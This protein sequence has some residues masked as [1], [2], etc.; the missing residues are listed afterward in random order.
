MVWFF[1]SISGKIRIKKCSSIQLYQK[2]IFSGKILINPITAPK[3]KTTLP[4]QKLK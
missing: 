4:T 2:N 1:L 3:N